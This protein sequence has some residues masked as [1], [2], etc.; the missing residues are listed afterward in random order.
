MLAASNAV[1]KNFWEHLEGKTKTCFKYV[2]DTDTKSIEGK[3]D[4]Q[5]WE[6]TVDALATI[7]VEGE[8]LY[9]L[10]RALCVVLQ[11]GNLVIEPDPNNLDD[12]SII[13]STE[14]LEHLA[15]LMGVEADDIR[16]SLTL[17]TVTAR[18]EEYKVPL[19]VTA[20]RDCRDAFSKEI[21]ACIFDWLVRTINA[22]TCAEENYAEAEQVLEDEED[23]GPGFKMI[24][25]LDI[26]GFESF[27]VNRFEQLC[28]NYANEKLQQKFT[29]DIFSSV[30]EEYEY[31]G[32]ELGE[33]NFTDN[34]DVLNLVEGRMGLI[35]V[36]NEECLRPKGNDISFVA[37]IRTLNKDTECLYQDKFH[38]DYEFEVKH[39]AGSVKYDA[40]SFVQKN[41]DKMPADLLD[42]ACKSSNEM[43][44]VELQKA[45]EARSDP[46]SG[47]ARRRGSLVSQS[48]S[49]KFRNQ[50]A[51]LMTLIGE[52][53]TRYIRCI[54]PNQDKKP[55][56]MKLPSTAE[57]LR[58]AGVV[59][60]VTIS[61]SSFPNRLSHRYTLE[62]FS[63]LINR[64]F[65]P[66][67]NDGDDDPALSQYCHDE[68]EKLLPKILA[69][70]DKSK[71]GI[72]L[73][74]FCLGKTR[75]Y[76]RAGALEYLEN[77]R[78]KSFSTHA[79][80]LQ[81]I[82]RGFIALQMYRKLRQ[83]AIRIQSRSRSCTASTKYRRLRAATISIQCFTRLVLA[84]K[85]LV[86][87]RRAHSS[88]LIQT[89]WRM[90]M[91]ISIRK[92]SIRA[93]IKIQAM[94]RGARQRPIYRAELA[95]AKEAAKLENQVKAL[96][97]KLEE[98]E[99]KR[100]EA[101][102]RASEAPTPQVQVVYKEAPSPIK[103]PRKDD[104]SSKASVSEK[105]TETKSAATLAA[106]SAAL[107]A[108]QQT[109]IDESGKML[110]YLRKEVFKLRSQNAQLRADFDVLKENNQRLMD[111][112]ASAGASFQALNQHAKTLAKSN[113]KLQSDL[114]NMKQQ[115]TK[116]NL[117]ELELKEELKMKQAT[118]IAE[119]HS[120]LQYQKTMGRIVEEIQA[121]CMDDRLVDD[122][123]M[124]S[125][126][127]E[128]DYMAGPTGMQPSPSPRSSNN[129]GLGGLLANAMSPTSEPRMMNN[130]K[131][132]AKNPD[133][134]GSRF[135][136]FIWGGAT[137]EV[138]ESGE[139]DSEETDSDSEEET[140]SEEEYERRRER[141][142]HVRKPGLNKLQA[143]GG[144]FSE[145]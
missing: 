109:L 25:L 143:F 91:A 97:K 133:T 66:P 6:R 63:T 8:Q 43:I 20:S 53:R 135:K 134:L 122:I 49:S 52:T 47:G 7:G 65:N 120:R 27:K 1:K 12:G 42:C 68:A 111:A 102:K 130:P 71:S 96:Q 82:I 3:T 100:L 140:D 14:E 31:E 32:I 116:H 117:V 112:N 5:H 50:L 16:N 48:V 2:G 119:V 24:G 39:Y 94:L 89:H 72:D 121:R 129:R 113:E 30:Q 55:R 92:T 40:N 85:T 17:R 37:K 13:T 11:L 95:E 10:M 29:V 54:K 77:E 73:A 59:A 60:A 107:T 46:S 138:N 75:V 74:P 18:N 70:Y 64:S 26:F 142:T 80:L 78:V 69:G 123:L 115:T 131:P 67:P 145:A 51:S 9:S 34:A 132:K 108:Q 103:S 125:D 118:Y 41:M 104:V 21:Y 139:S 15:E 141:M 19:N 86:F 62:R 33:V 35:S 83:A 79:I 101:E 4:E 126:D 106:S 110:E 76:F 87:L 136:S 22:A 28:I 114:N 23:E 128:S 93:V 36:L 56:R 58:C 84:G 45:Q 44:R 90:A 144:G 98:A 61:R 127:C 124:M 137:E 88:T 81:K 57:Q 99:A 38:R 105:T